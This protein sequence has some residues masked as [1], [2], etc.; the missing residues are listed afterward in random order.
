MSWQNGVGCDNHE[1]IIP[2]QEVLGGAPSANDGNYPW[3]TKVDEFRP[4]YFYREPWEFNV[5]NT[6][7][8]ELP[9]YQK[10][11]KILEQRVGLLGEYYS[12][13]FDLC[14]AFV[15][16]PKLYQNQREKDRGVHLL[17]QIT[18]K[19]S[20]SY[21]YTENDTLKLDH[22]SSK[23]KPNL[24]SEYLKEGLKELNFKKIVIR[25]SAW[26]LLL[27]ELEFLGG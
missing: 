22:V 12:L 9:P 26:D 2:S 16:E 3:L 21:F 8:G 7:S 15:F 14:H 27:Q 25:G 23:S 4:G 11:I 1:I 10:A 24:P 6:A 18:E 20:L 17:K 5:K 13:K 19:I